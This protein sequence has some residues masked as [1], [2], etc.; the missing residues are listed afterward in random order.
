MRD[1]SF[2]ARGAGAEPLF[3]DQPAGADELSAVAETRVDAAFELGC[4]AGLKLA[5][6]D[7]LLTAQ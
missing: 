4:R 6:G 7:P 5:P 2:S 1:A 3:L